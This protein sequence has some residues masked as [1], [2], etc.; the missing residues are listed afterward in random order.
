M[1]IWVGNFNLTVFALTLIFAT[2]LSFYSEPEAPFYVWIFAQ[3]PATF[4]YKKLVIAGVYANLL[5]LPICILA[6]IFFSDS[7]WIIILFLFLGSLF[8]ITTIL[9]KYADFPRYI[10]LPS[11]IFLGLS[12]VFPPL[13]LI[14]IPYFYKKA[15]Q[16]LNLILA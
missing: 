12:L 8:L 15:I 4:L 5:A 9:A 3:S 13:L 2:C 16:Q 7:W 14:L 11:T 1:G 10:G 6:L